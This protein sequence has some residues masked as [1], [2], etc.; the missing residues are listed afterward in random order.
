MLRHR[1]LGA[2]RDEIRSWLTADFVLEEAGPDELSDDVR[3]WRAV[4]RDPGGFSFAFRVCEP[5]GPELL[6]RELGGCR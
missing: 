1:P 3:S 5:L 2:L 4:M 6:G